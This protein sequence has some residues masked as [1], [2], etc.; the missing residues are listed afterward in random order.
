MVGGNGG[1]GGGGGGGGPVP[2]V[3]TATDMRVLGLADVGRLGE[4]IL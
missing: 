3:C 4:Y 1:G 2:V